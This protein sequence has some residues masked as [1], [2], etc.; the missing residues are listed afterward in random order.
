[1]AFWHGRRAGLGG[2]Y[3]SDGDGNDGA[4]SAIESGR[5]YDTRSCN[6]WTCTLAIRCIPLGHIL[7]WSDGRCY[8][9]VVR[10][11]QIIRPSQT[12]AHTGTLTTTT[13]IRG[14]GLRLIVKT[15][16]IPSLYESIYTV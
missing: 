14:A 1:M 9:V 5:V 2:I 4:L 16:S 7:Q 10:S 3:W 12:C 15:M 8:R 11:G 6:L 13:A